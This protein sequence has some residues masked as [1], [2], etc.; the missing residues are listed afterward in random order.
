MTNA[1]GA[2]TYCWHYLENVHC[3]KHITARSTKPIRSCMLSTAY[4]SP[5]LS[6][7]HSS[8][9]QRV[10]NMASNTTCLH[11]SLQ[12]GPK[13][14]ALGLQSVVSDPKC[15]QQCT[16]AEQVARLPFMAYKY[17]PVS[18]VLWLVL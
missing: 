5:H 15:F 16:V 13:L 2:S 4:Y 6:T 12:G 8:T 9:A 11:W 3:R 17:H 10:A 14:T 18:Q 1:M 7:S